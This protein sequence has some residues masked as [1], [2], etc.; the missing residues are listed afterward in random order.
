[1]ANSYCYLNSQWDAHV[2]SLGNESG[3]LWARDNARMG[4]GRGGCFGA[5]AAPESIRNMSN[6]IKGNLWERR[7]WKIKS[8][9]VSHILFKWGSTFSWIMVCYNHIFIW[10]LWFA[11]TSPLPLEIFFSRAGKAMVCH[12]GWH[13]GS[14]SNERLYQLIFTD[15]RGG[16]EKNLSLK[17]AAHNENQHSRSLQWHMIAHHWLSVTRCLRHT[18]SWAY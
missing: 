6:F 9:F 2:P 4:G 15:Y 18:Q 17:S 10:S 5:A 1:M 11:D 13:A 7:E 3:R 16:K 14:G 12:G 8:G